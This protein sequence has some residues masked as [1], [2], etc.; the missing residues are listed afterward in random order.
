MSVMNS[1]KMTQFTLITEKDRISN[2]KDC[3]P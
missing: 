1:L 3:L 2:K